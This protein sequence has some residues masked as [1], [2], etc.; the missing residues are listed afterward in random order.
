[1]PADARI[2]QD[3]LKWKRYRAYLRKPQRGLTM[4]EKIKFA[5]FSEKLPSY[6]GT[7]QGAIRTSNKGVGVSLGTVRCGFIVYTCPSRLPTLFSV[8]SGSD[9]QQQ[10][11]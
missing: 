10:V 11:P 6:L 3:T 5:V 7:S 1:M 2:S 9:T 4:A 8:K